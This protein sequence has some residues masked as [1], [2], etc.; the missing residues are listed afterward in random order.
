MGAAAPGGGGAYPRRNNNCW[1]DRAM[2]LP[3]TQNLKGGPAACFPE[4]S[5]EI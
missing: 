2:Q 1:N 5:F 3:K 4:K